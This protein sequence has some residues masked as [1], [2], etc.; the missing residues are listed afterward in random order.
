[1]H[2]LML[3]FSGYNLTIQVFIV[4]WIFSVYICSLYS[5]ILSEC[6]INMSIRD[7]NRDGSMEEIRWRH[8]PLLSECSCTNYVH[9]I[10]FF[11]LEL[12]LICTILLIKGCLMVC[13]SCPSIL[14]SSLRAFLM[15]GAPFDLLIIWW[16]LS[17]MKQNMNTVIYV[18][19][20]I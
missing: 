9:K 1:M 8:G 14:N 20:W 18:V 11:L 7:G 10:G 17:I 2:L 13:I 16:S 15:S 19:A 3:F 5:V 12:K 4:I 6:L